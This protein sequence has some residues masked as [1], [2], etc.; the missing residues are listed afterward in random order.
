MT[1]GLR[2]RLA[3]GGIV[4]AIFLVLAPLTLSMPGDGLD[5][6]WGLVMEQAFLRGWQW[7]RDIVFTFGPFGYHF[8]RI[9]HPDLAAGLLAAS[10]VRALLIGLGVALLLEHART[11]QIG[12]VLVAVALAL[13][14]STDSA[15]FLLPVLAVLVHARGA[16]RSALWYLLA[17][18][19][20]CG[21][22]ALIKTTF[23]VLALVLLEIVDIDRMTQ[24]R[25][26]VLTPF[27]VAGALLAYTAAGQPIAALPDFVALSLDVASGFSRAMAVFSALRAI[28]LAAFLAASVA[29]L[30]LLIVQAVREQALQ[31]RSVRLM[32]L[33]LAVFWFVT[34]KAGFTRHDLHSL[35]AWSCLGIAGVLVAAILRDG[36]LSRLLMA[37]ALCV[38]LL[39]PIRLSIAPGFSL[40]GL[41]RQAL[42]DNPIGTLVTGAR[43]IADPSGW[44]AERQ[45]QRNAV[46][47]RIRMRN[48][49]PEG[50]GRVDTVPSIQ[51]ALIA[52][53]LA[54]TATYAPRPVFQEYST[55]TAALIEANRRFLEGDDAPQ[56]MLLAPGS[57][58]NRYPSLAGG[59]LWPVLM[60][61]YEA[62]RRIGPVQHLDGKIDV[63][64]LRRR[65]EDAPDGV[66]PG[67]TLPTRP[68]QR[69]ELP[70]LDGP[71]LATIDLRL[72]AAGRLLTLL[73]QMPT[74][75]IAV[76]LADGSERRHRLIPGIARAGFILSPYMA[77]A[78]DARALF[79]EF[80]G[81]EDPHRVTSVQV[82]VP[83]LA[84]WAFADQFAL[85]LHPL[86]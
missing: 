82:D 85:T 55:Y 54:G 59:P 16:E 26:P 36:W 44:A 67:E 58:D 73:H 7:G 64:V 74:V 15:Y 42:V 53:D 76:T 10:A 57:I 70:A 45:A 24:R 25:P 32:L 19:A 8:Q 62:V 14:F 39:T 47:D 66:G 75:E 27:L 80:D 37:V 41:V 83:D 79:E 33:A 29:I 56:T 49:L 3:L 46:L 34:Y 86:R 78:A 52:A 81:K 48:A 11:W 9:F 5:P 38:A 69:V 77:D 1:A 4:V 50:L 23:A 22:A 28:E 30:G 13:P 35:T 68:G 61:R 72:S 60:R 31:D 21:F 63:L 65:A 6:S 40:G 18:A 12:A 20:Y 84:D 43:L 2:H 51:G 17:V 71:I